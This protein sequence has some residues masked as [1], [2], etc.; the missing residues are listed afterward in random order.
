MLTEKEKI[1]LTKTFKHTLEGYIEYKNVN[2]W[3]EDKGFIDK[4][5]INNI[6]YWLIYDVE[7]QYLKEVK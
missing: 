2:E 5:N 6:V 7:N 4:D 3:K 1:K